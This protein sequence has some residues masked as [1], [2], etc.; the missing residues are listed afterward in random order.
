MCFSR[1]GLERLSDSENDII[2]L[3]MDAIEHVACTYSIVSL[4]DLRPLRHT[5]FRGLR[6][7]CPLNSTACPF[8]CFSLKSHQPITTVRELV[9]RFPKIGVPNLDVG[10]RVH[11][12][13]TNQLM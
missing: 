3:S 6:R 1:K 7:L 10:L 13:N 5:D 12:T 9:V 4:S 8:R 2:F 11:N